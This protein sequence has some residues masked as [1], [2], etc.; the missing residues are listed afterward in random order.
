MLTGGIQ[1]T[2]RDPLVC[3]VQSY[4]KNGKPVA[5]VVLLCGTKMFRN[6]KGLEPG[7]V[8]IGDYT[9]QAFVHFATLLQLM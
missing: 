4:L 1:K 7:T 3:E 6:R 2:G 5:K 9:F 8:G